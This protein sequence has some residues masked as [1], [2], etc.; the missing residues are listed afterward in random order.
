MIACVGLGQIGEPVCAN[1]L[2]CG[3]Q[4][5]VV[6]HAARA[7]I[8][9]LCALGAVERDSVEQLLAAADV[10]FLALPDAA[11][12]REV[13]SVAA[14]SRSAT[15]IDLS[16][17]GV[18][19][20]IQIGAELERH[21]VRYVDAPVSG[22]SAGAREATLTVMLGGRE[23]EFVELQPLL[24]AIA[25]TVIYCGRRGHGAAVKLANNLL[26]GVQLA[27]LREAMA[28][29]AGAGVDTELLFRV[30]SASSGNSSILQ[31]K[32]S[33]ILQQDFRPGFSLELMY[34]DLGLA[35]SE[36][37]GFGS[38][39]PLVGAALA[40]FRSC[41]DDWGSQDCSVVTQCR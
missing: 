6:Q 4:V 28:L 33:S 1:L 31:A 36:L 9:R 30:L 8:E 5:G 23:Q 22:G 35:A 32:Q 21:G 26:V 29:S 12:V 2:R 3:Y 15:V 27:A 41:V 18:G 40:T 11:A 24:N 34:K 7:P 16:T 38:Q 14:W 17:I 13:V 25:G 19:Q 37:E 20:S 39:H 10:V